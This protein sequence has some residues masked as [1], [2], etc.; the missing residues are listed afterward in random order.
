MNPVCNHFYE[1]LAPR[2][3]CLD[4]EKDKRKAYDEGNKAVKEY[5]KEHFSELIGKD[6]DELISI[7]K[8]VF[9][10]R[11]KKYYKWL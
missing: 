11:A 3:I 5:A 2:H 1:K 4:W 6:K 9:R 10:D 7:Y 8:Q